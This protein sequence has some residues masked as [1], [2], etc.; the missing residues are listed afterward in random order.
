MINQGNTAQA[1]ASIGQ[2]WERLSDTQKG[3]VQKMVGAYGGSVS[4]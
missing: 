3:Q 2:I 4:A 1:E